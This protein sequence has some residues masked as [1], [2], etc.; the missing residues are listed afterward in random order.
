MNLFQLTEIGLAVVIIALGIASC[1][2]GSKIFKFI[3]VILGFFIGAYF[4]GKFG[5]AFI[6]DTNVLI[7]ASIA[8]GL[9]L[10]LLVLFFYYVGVFF[11]GVAIVLMASS[12]LNL[13][14][15]NTDQ[16]IILLILCAIGGVLT[17]IFH[18]FILTIATAA[19]GG[20]AITNGAGFLFFYFFKKK[21]TFDQYL[22]NLKT[23]TSI[24]YVI[25]L[26]TI[27]LTILG[28]INQFRLTH[29]DT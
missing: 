11:S 29:H 23:E 22:A 5:S 21:M 28:I 25:I 9:V 16:L 2:Y 27:V 8:G 20:W 17:L 3:L 15:Q 10:G 7:I 24:L 12:Y 14:Y 4:F 18:D 19:I 6:D 1:F 26:F 13:N